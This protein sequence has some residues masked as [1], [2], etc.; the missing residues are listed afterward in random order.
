MNFLLSKSNIIILIMQVVF[1][2]SSL[3]LNSLK[4]KDISE[5]ELQ[6]ISSFNQSFLEYKGTQS[7]SVVHILIR[8]V[9]TSNQSSEHK[10]QVLLNDS[11]D[12]S[13]ESIADTQKYNIYFHYNDNGYIDG[14]IIRTIQ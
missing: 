12:F 8:A 2:F 3:N 14:A 6:A 9:Q 5:D 1:G 13:L 11:Y 4:P 7:G 10:I